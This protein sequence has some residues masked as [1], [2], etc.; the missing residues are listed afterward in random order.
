[1]VIFVEYLKSILT[2]EQVTLAPHQILD[3]EISEMLMNKQEVRNIIQKLLNS[4]ELTGDV[5]VYQFNV[6]T[7]DLIAHTGKEET[8]EAFLLEKEILRSIHQ[9]PIFGTDDEPFHL[10]LPLFAKEKL[11][12]ALCILTPQESQPWDTLYT[13]MFK[14]SAIL[15]QYNMLIENRENAV[16]DRITNLYNQEHFYDMLD[17][18][19]K[20]VDRYGGKLALLLLRIEN[21]NVINQ[22]LGYAAGNQVLKEVGHTIGY[23][24]RNIDMPARLENNL[25]AIALDQTDLAGAYVVALRLVEKIQ[26]KTLTI[27]NQP[28]K[29]R[30]ESSILPYSATTNN[31]QSFIEVCQASLKYNSPQV[32]EKLLNKEI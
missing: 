8:C 12:G 2:K 6:N 9:Q 27:Q 23:T 13:F 18:I 16:K 26:R 15:L 25:F 21:H 28:L 19:I 24:L 31:P 3:A 1:M 30:I 22:K 7:Y 10:I 29:I 11:L 4:L 17:I 32:L 14:S 5:G 20:K